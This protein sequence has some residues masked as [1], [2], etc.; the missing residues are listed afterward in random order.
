MWFHDLT[1][2]AQ[3]DPLIEQLPRAKV[4]PGMWDMKP[5]PCGFYLS[6]TRTRVSE[7]KA[8]GKHVDV[9]KGFC[10]CDVYAEL[11][12][13]LAGPSGGHGGGGG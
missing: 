12:R 4:W 2:L 7:G 9:R 11:G 1:E 13:I 10:S 3:L 8:L 5:N 6:L